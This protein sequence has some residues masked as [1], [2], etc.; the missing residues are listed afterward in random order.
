MGIHLLALLLCASCGGLVQPW[1]GAGG[2]RSHVPATANPAT[3]PPRTR[4]QLVVKRGRTAYLHPRELGRDPTLGWSPE[5]PEN[6]KVQV[7]HNDPMTQRVGR[8]TPLVSL[9]C[10]FHTHIIIS[11]S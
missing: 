6:C 1:S 9:S 7:V 8:I 10:L 2:G 4:G 3:F 11:T 5:E